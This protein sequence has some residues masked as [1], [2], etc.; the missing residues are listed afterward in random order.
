M[1]DFAK[2]Y[3]SYERAF[4]MAVLKAKGFPPQILAIIHTIHENTTVRFMVNGFTSEKM[5]LTSE[6]RQGCPLHPLL[7]IIAVDLLYDAIEHDPE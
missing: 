5:K 7:F 1:L 6:I 4:L 2:A 3:D